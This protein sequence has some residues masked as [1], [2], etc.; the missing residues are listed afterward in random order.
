MTLCAELGRSSTSDYV[1]R[2]GFQLPVSG[3]ALLSPYR[4][5]GRGNSDFRFFLW[6]RQ[7]CVLIEWHLFT[8]ASMLCSRVA[9][10]CSSGVLG[11]CNYRRPVY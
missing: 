11:F 2:S 4:V 6:P 10:I 5:W 9:F 3:P 1:C 7:R 8:Y